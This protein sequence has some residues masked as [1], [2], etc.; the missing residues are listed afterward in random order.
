MSGFVVKQKWKRAHTSA[1]VNQNPFYSVGLKTCGFYCSWTWNNWTTLL[2]RWRPKPSQTASSLH[3]GFSHTPSSLHPQMEPIPSP[4]WDSADGC[5]VPSLT[6]H[7]SGFSSN[8]DHAKTGLHV[9]EET[10]TQAGKEG[11]LERPST[12]LQLKSQG[13][14]IT[15]SW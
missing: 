5:A 10:Q 6:S 3:P 11:Q 15:P 4:W 13:G 9:T 8:H 2:S 1:P 14:G 12:H 7:V